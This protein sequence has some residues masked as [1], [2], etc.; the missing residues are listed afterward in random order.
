[1]LKQGNTITLSTPEVAQAYFRSEM[2]RYAAL[3][4]KAGV[5]LQ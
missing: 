3:V 2:L 5:E 1:M 4:K